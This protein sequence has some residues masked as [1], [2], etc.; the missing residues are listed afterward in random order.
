MKSDRPDEFLW[1]VATSAYQIEGGIDND[2]SRWEA[3]GRFRRNG[4]DPQVG[5]SVDHW[6][7]WESDFD[8]LAGLGVNS[9][10][11]SIEWA[12]LEPA[13]GQFDDQAFARYARMLE[14]LRTLRI[15][16]MVTL[17]HFTHPAW[18][19][20]RTPWHLP[21]SVDT[22]LAFVDQVC[23]RL[24]ADVPYVITLNEPMVWLLGGYGD[25]RLPPGERNMNRLIVALHHMLLAH[26]A[27]YDV[28]KNRHPHM[29]IGIAHNMIAFRRARPGH[30]LDGEIKRRLHRFYNLLI[31]KTFLSNRLK[32]YFPLAVTY[33]QPIDLD[34]RIDFW[35][36]NYYY[37]SHVRF[38]L[39]P[40]RPFEMLFVPRSKHGLSDLGWEIYPRG[41]Y[42][43]CR[44]LRFTDKP[45][46]ITENGVASDDD[47]VRVRFLQRHLDFLGRLRSEGMDIRGYYH[48]S[49]LDN[50][51]WL[52]GTSARFGLYEVDYANNL[53]RLPRPSAAFYA[54]HIAAQRQPY[55][56]AH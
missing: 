38:R 55:P 46:M 19:H 43:C 49:L 37:R 45:L 18:F 11:F 48:W 16:P 53:D 30:I 50:Y 54:Q 40:F 35:G 4:L 29:Q 10:R 44:W 56:P 21:A 23:Q 9:Y 51:E 28:L 32:F 6:N 52:V 5:K 25:A 33:D 34:N 8:L 1:G 39:R 24:L 7:R 26:R 31:P 15:A 47:A 14:R 41:L 20:E 36:I 13:P 27:A 12:R 3:S 42:K 17:H 22:F 2:M